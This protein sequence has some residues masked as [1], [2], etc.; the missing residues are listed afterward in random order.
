VGVSGGNLGA[1][2]ALNSLRIV[3]R[4]LHAWVVPEQVSVT[5]ASQ[6]FDPDGKP[7]DAGLSENLMQVGRQV[8]RFSYL[9]TSK[10]ALD[11]LHLW[12]TAPHNPGGY[13]Q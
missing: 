4:S 2:N 7:V 3:C 13:T 1:V 5:Q 12:E 8:A 10:Q 9:H 11:F 6:Q